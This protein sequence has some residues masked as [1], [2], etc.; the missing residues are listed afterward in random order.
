MTR[1]LRYRMSIIAG[2]LAGALALAG[3]L[4]GCPAPPEGVPGSGVGVFNNTTDPT[5][6]NARYIGSSACVACHASICEITERHAHSQ[7]LKVPNGVAPV[8]PDGRH[9]GGGA[10]SAGR[11]WR[12]LD[13]SAT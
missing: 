5:N 1:H 3:V 11:F 10:Q 8:Y 4:A 6:N 12:G 7:A 13:V 2:G 9:A